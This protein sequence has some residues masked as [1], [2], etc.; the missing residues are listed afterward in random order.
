ML[1]RLI[2]YKTYLDRARS[3]M[4]YVQFTAMLLVMLKVYDET[5]WGA[6]MFAHKGILV[7]VFVLIFGIMVI[8]GY[9]DK[10]YIRPKETSEINSVN[11]E[12]MEMHEKIM[13]CL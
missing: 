2:R 8:A 7:L 9:L 1:S 6:W 11:P 5:T 4:G 13:K 12:F 3:Y 10:K